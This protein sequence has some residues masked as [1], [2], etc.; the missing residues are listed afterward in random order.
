MTKVSQKNSFKGFDIKTFLLGFKKPSIILI[1]MGIGYLM[2]NPIG[3]EA[4]TLLGGSA[5]IVERL[6]ALIE[7]YIKKIT[8]K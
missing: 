5:V 3:A 8:L 1:T 6:W 4:I 7:F 2:T